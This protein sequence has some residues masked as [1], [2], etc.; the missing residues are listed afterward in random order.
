[1]QYLK[2]RPLFQISAS[3]MKFVCFATV[4]CFLQLQANC[5]AESLV[6]F[7]G[8][9]SVIE[10]KRLQ[11]SEHKFFDFLRDESIP[12]RRR[13]VFVPY[14]TF[15]A[16]T[17][18]DILD[19]WIRVPE[20]KNELELRINVFVEEDNFHYNLFLHDVEAVLGYSVDKFGQ[21]IV[22]FM[23]VIYTCSINTC[24]HVVVRHFVFVKLPPR[25]PTTSRPTFTVIVLGR[26][27]YVRCK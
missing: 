13:M 23:H 6:K 17:A 4:V 10:E 1:M 7:Q 20:P 26:R 24:V 11:L 9:I 14:W 15:Y 16:L 12:E 18:A 19:S 3:E 21:L 22:Q 5:T 2:R 8:V 25:F 27:M